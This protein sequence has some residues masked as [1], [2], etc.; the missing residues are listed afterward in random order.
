LSKKRMQGLAILLLLVASIGSGIPLSF[1]QRPLSYTV[2]VSISNQRIT[3]PWDSRANVT[4]TISGL[5]DFRNGTVKVHSDAPELLVN[6][7]YLQGFYVGTN[8]VV[9][10]WLDE[11]PRVDSEEKAATA[12]YTFRGINCEWLNDYDICSHYSTYT[13]KIRIIGSM[14]LDLSAINPGSYHVEVAFIV[15]AA[16]TDHK[17]DNSVSYEVLDSWQTYLWVP[18]AILGAILIIGV[19]VLMSRRLRRSLATASIVFV[20]AAILTIAHL[21][22][23]TRALFRT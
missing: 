22:L 6:T 2:D 5:G 20:I 17:F 13:S 3:K 18:F 23:R 1:S 15:Y 4:F 11:Y 9:Y 10:Q 16:G 14:I 8:E 19:A 21:R 7:F 12:Q